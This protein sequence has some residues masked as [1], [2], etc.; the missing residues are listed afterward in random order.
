MNKEQIVEILRSNTTLHTLALIP[1]S[2]WIIL[3]DDFEQIADE[4]LALLASRWGEL[5]DDDAFYLE[6][7]QIERIDEQTEDS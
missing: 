5:E 3:R 2:Q 6:L 4:I 7:H 1:D